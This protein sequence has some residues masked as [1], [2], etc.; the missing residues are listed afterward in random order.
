MRLERPAAIG[1]VF[2]SLALLVGPI[3]SPAATIDSG[4]FGAWTTSEADCK[5]LFVRSGG[6]LAFRQP[7]DKFAQAAIIEPQQIRLPASVCRVENVT[8]ETG[9]TKIAA[10]CHDTISYTAQTVTIR[11]KSPGEIVYSPTGDSA[12]DTSLVKCGM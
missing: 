6:G 7:V 5:R 11:M 3:A 2:G 10:E 9:A 4:L 8:H 1:V 12:L